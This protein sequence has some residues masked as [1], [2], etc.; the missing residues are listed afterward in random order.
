MTTPTETEPIDAAADAAGSAVRGARGWFRLAT[1]Y[2]AV[3][4]RA[5]G[6]VQVA[7]FDDGTFRL[8]I[9]ETGY[10][11]AVGPYDDDVDASDVCDAV[12]QL[13]YN[14]TA[15]PPATPPAGG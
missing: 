12:L 4:L 10:V 11:L 15:W 3:N 13:S 8:V 5:A 6:S 2:G 9:P 7:Q 1:G 14:D